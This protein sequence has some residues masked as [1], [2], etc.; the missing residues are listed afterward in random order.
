MS[1]R[2]KLER[3]EVAD[4]I[5]PSLLALTEFPEE[6]VSA[7]QYPGRFFIHQDTITITRCLIYN[8]G[9]GNTAASGV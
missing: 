3:S 2:G 5:Q 7:L 8:L 6:C 1:S 4:V 9:D